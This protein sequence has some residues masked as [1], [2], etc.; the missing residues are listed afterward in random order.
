MLYYL[1]EGIIIIEGHLSSTSNP[2][3]N[4]GNFTHIFSELPNY[5]KGLNMKK[6]VSPDMANKILENNTVN[7]KAKPSMVAFLAE[8]MISRRFVYNGE[9]IIISETNKLLDGQH[10]LLAIV[11]S[12]ISCM[13]NIE[14][15]VAD[16]AMNTIDTGSART[17]GDVLEINGIEHSKNISGAIRLILDEMGTK[18][19]RPHLTVKGKKVGTI[20]ISHSEILDF[21]NNNTDKIRAFY[22]Y[23]SHLYSSGIKVIPP[24]HATAYLYLMSKSNDLDL[25]KS[26]IRE[27]YTGVQEGQS[28]AAI[29]AHKKL[30]NDKISISSMAKREKIN[31]ILYAFAKYRDGILVSQLKSSTTFAGFLNFENI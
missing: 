23:C 4:S 28:N 8:E 10:R 2:D 19:K 3:E 18:P 26:F 6:L 29:K 24:A 31:L 9:S 30:V 12:G 5:P 11:E 13:L 27:I 14:Y 7:R 25:V 1:K 22:L 16:S 20:K 15:G 21:Y 17:A